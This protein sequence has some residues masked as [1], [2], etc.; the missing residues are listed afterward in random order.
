MVQPDKSLGGTQEENPIVFLVF[1]HFDSLQGVRKRG[2]FRNNSVHFHIPVICTI[3]EDICETKVIDGKPIEDNGVK[4]REVKG[5]IQ[6]FSFGAFMLN[7]ITSNEVRG[8]AMH[9]AK[10]VSNGIWIEDLHPSARSRP[11]VDVK[12]ELPSEAGGEMV[13]ESVITLHNKV[14]KDEAAKEPELVTINKKLSSELNKIEES[15]SDGKETPPFDSQLEDFLNKHRKELIGTL[16]DLIKSSNAPEFMGVIR[17]KQA[18][19]DYLEKVLEEFDKHGRNWENA[20]KVLMKNKFFH[21]IMPWLE[22]NKNRSDIKELIRPDPRPAIFALIEAS[23]RALIP[24]GVNHFNFFTKESKEKTEFMKKFDSLHKFLSE[25]V[26]G[27]SVDDVLTVF[28]LKQFPHEEDPKKTCYQSLV[29]VDHAIK[30]RED[31]EHLL[32]LAKWLSIFWQ[33]EPNWDLGIPDNHNEGRLEQARIDIHEEICE[34]LGLSF[35]KEKPKNP[36]LRRCKP[37][38]YAKIDTSNDEKMVFTE[39]LGK[40]LC[41]RTSTLEEGNGNKNGWRFRSADPK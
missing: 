38:S 9:Q 30:Y 5:S 24:G 41:Y 28:A 39:E 37:V 27:L 40:T 32:N 19:F 25:R 31:K 17:N 20:A 3:P 14:E 23:M 7:V 29:K 15:S 34:V 36:K 8:P 22:N 11:L 18:L 1:T 2:V 33:T 16:K 13:K 35:E 12:F 4:Y 10:I 26:Y 6:V 21:E